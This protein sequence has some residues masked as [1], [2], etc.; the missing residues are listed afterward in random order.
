MTTGF[1]RG[2]DR[3]ATGPRGRISKRQYQSAAQCPKRLWLE[4]YRGDIATPPT[5]DT[6]FRQAQGIEIGR[7]AHWLHPNGRHVQRELDFETHL[8]HSR[9][10][11]AERRP[12][13][14]AAFAT[15]EA[16]A[17]VDLLVPRGTRAWELI[18]VKSAT[19]VR[20]RAKV[21]RILPRYLDDVA[22][23]T[24]V[25]EA[26]GVELEAVSL[27]FLNTEYARE[28]EV[29]PARLFQTTDAT[30]EARA[31]ATI[32][33][34]GIADARAVRAW[35]E[36]PVVS[37]G[38][39][40]STPYDCPFI[41]HCWADVPE[42]SVHTLYR[43][44]KLAHR[45]WAAGVRTVAEIPG[46]TKISPVQAVQIA[47]S[48]NGRP[49]ID[50]AAIKQY[51]DGLRFP[52]YFLDFETLQTAVPLYAGV[53]PYQQIPFQFSLHVLASPEAAPEHTEFLANG[54]NDPRPALL[55]ALA[56][57]IGDEGSVVSYNA[58]FERDRLKEMAGTFPAHAGWIGRAL[59]RFKGADLLQPFRSFSYYDP[60]QRGS[61]SIKDVLPVLTDITYEH[62]P[63]A[64][65]AVAASEYVRVAVHEPN[66][67]DA[68]IVRAN[69]FRYCE[70]DTL[71]LVE[72][73]RRLRQLVAAT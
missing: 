7:L 4:T 34:R 18:E 9:E 50:S 35:V 46:E 70:Q 20:G 29:E 56:S 3:E 19:R 21:P 31:A 62:L 40:C 23:Q 41:K 72:V 17:R 59:K 5:T 12:L 60:R 71:A 52:L 37:I 73:Y 14:E 36:P 65:G 58:P 67:A 22:F 63:I 27:M 42:D 25:V 16:Y 44:G 33:P 13:F 47:A 8:A 1:P 61:A 64:N 28:Q 11:L 68:A 49:H 15:D 57:V 24:H 10:A 69:L 30:A 6:S 66:A 39:H 51:L 26:A 48:R 32:V 38:T 45:L 2:A 55:D 54:P 53:H 43:G